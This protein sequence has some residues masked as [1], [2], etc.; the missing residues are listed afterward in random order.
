MQLHVRAHKQSIYLLPVI[1]WTD[2]MGGNRTFLPKVCGPG[3]SCAVDIAN[4]R[5][6]VRGNVVHERCGEL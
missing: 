2:L 5:G 1:A 4:W 3:A 6:A